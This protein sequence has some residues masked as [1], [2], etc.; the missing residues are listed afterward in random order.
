MAR[1]SSRFWPDTYQIKVTLV[2]SRPA[3]WRRILV[4]CDMN[5]TDLHHTLQIVMGWEDS[6]IHQ[7]QVGQEVYG[8]P[9][10]EYP[11]DVKNEARVMVKKVFS[12]L[13][14][15]ILYE[16]DFGDGWEHKLEL[17]KVIPHQEGEP[18]PRCLDGKRACPPEDSGG[19]G[20]YKHLL[21]VVRDS[22]HPDHRELSEWLGEGF[23]PEYLD[24]SAVNYELGEN[25]GRSAR[26][27]F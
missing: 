12:E 24:L 19:I 16:Y 20:G 22:E 26:G 14:S 15:V 21:Q 18:L 10:P 17:E 9:D 2:G 25:F 4:R 7:F 6:H 11:R 23:D 1:R 27:D 3:I 5:L 8:V 13:G